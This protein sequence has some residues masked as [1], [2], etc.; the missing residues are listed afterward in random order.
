MTFLLTREGGALLDVDTLLDVAGT[1]VGGAPATSPA[2]IPA[3]IGLLA[4]VRLALDDP[5]LGRALL[6]SFERQAADARVAP[7]EVFEENIRDLV[8][9]LLE[10]ATVEGP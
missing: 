5:A 10:L 8:G 3:T 7:A 1:V 2:P 6:A 4:G 9:V